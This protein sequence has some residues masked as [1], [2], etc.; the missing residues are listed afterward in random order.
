MP[1]SRS[2][3]PRNPSSAARRRQRRRRYDEAR[4]LQRSTA[5]EVAATLTDAHRASMRAA[6]DAELR[7]DPAAALAHYE[8]VPM[9][10]DSLHH[11]RLRLLAELGEDAPGW[12]WSR[13]LTVQARRPLWTGSA[14]TAPDP[15]LRTTLEVAYPHGFD[16]DPMED[17]SPDVFLA[18]LYERDWVLRQL[19]VYEDGRL[20]DVVEHLAAPRLLERADHVAAWPDVPVGG[21]R[22]DSDAGEH[23]RLTDLGSGERLDV[24]DLG[25]AFE[26][27]PGSHFLGRVVPTDVAPGRMF[28]WRPLPVDE[29]TARRVADRP[30]AWLR[31]LAERAREALPPMFSY[32]EDTSMMSDLPV[33]SWLELLEHKD[34]DDLPAPDGLI[35]YHDVA[36]AV[37]P[38]LLRVA[39]HVP[40]RVECT[41]HLAEALVLE[42][43]LYD[44]LRAR[45]G[46]RRW[47]RAWWTLAGAVREPA[48]GRCLRLAGTRYDDAGAEAV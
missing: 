48:R 4:T 15:A 47:A 28:E 36:L 35:D 45:F 37:T 22:L 5:G 21:Y 34:I 30:D 14:S 3:R 13:W 32:V 27:W 42:P 8:A 2:R 29:G 6:A 31:T 18:M 43:G 39:E 12:L 7:G 23:L 38:K 40:E 9:I 10:A 1:Q 46:G 24:L 26:H 33:R 44:A 11:Q 19:N 25:L 16:P 17:F 20:R 41:R